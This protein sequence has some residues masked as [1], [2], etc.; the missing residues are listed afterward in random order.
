MEQACR[1]LGESELEVGEGGGG[2]VE[3]STVQGAC[4][5]SGSLYAPAL[6]R[7]GQLHTM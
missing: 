4:H 3:G 6:E 2:G 7:P 5:V 1:E